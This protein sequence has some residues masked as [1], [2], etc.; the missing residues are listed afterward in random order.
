[1]IEAVDGNEALR[2]AFETLPDLILLDIMMPH[3]DGYQVCEELKGDART[4][5]TP[6]VFLSAKTGVEDK[7]RGLE[8][9]GADYVTKPFNKDEVLARVR[10]QLKIGK[11]TS[12]LMAANIALENKQK[13]IDM[14][15]Q[16]A[17]GIQQ[18]LLPQKMPNTDGLEIAWRFL[19]CDQ[20]GRGHFQHRT[21]R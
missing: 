21:A 3:K 4:A 19:P 9:G 14:D 8:L 20:I 2:K 16:A 12:E 7:I 10:T 5:H 6:I 15:L 11:L 13:R 17:A 18:S 1:M